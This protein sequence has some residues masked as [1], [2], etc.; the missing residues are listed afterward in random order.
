M[1][2]AREQHCYSLNDGPERTSVFLL[3]CSMARKEGRKGGRDDEPSPF[4][5]AFTLEICRSGQFFIYQRCY[6]LGAS[7]SLSAP[8]DVQRMTR[9]RLRDMKRECVCVCWELCSEWRSLAG[10]TRQ[11][12]K[13][14]GRK[15]NS[16]RLLEEIHRSIA[17]TGIEK[18]KKEKKEKKKK[19]GRRKQGN[20]KSCSVFMSTWSKSI[21]IGN[22]VD[23]FD[24][25]K[26]EMVGGWG[27]PLP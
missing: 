5:H 3:I 7:L 10:R 19:N 27:A 23:T 6:Y 13:K 18:T 25:D 22:L 2:D 8:Q 11:A 24:I 4:V 16:G 12:W 20:S 26:E 15:S 17:I 1:V 9:E 14:D 21:R